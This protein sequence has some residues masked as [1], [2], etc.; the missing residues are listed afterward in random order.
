MFE[1]QKNKSSNNPFG[2]QCFVIHP[3]HFT[4]R[5]NLAIMTYNYAYDFGFAVKKIDYELIDYVKVIP[6]KSVT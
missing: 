1:Q 6:T 4:G 5:F 3:N 2:I